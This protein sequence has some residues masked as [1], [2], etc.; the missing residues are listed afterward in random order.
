MPELFSGAGPSRP[1]KIRQ[2]IDGLR[3]GG[4]PLTPYYYGRH[5]EPPIYEGLLTATESRSSPPQDYKITAG[6][7][8]ARTDG[9]EVTLAESTRWKAC[10]V[11]RA[12]ATRHPNWTDSRARFARLGQSCLKTPPVGRF[13]SSSTAAKFNL[14]LRRGDLG[15]GYAG[16]GR[17]SPHLYRRGAAQALQMAEESTDTINRPG[18]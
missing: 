3:H 12:F 18:C 13:F 9:R 4:L 11:G 10:Y 6:V 7:P 14:E 2:T 8:L 15:A 16:G 1:I 17:F 5:L